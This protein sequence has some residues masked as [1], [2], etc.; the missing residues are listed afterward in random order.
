ME[1]EK[2]TTLTAITSGAKYFS[3]VRSPAPS[4]TQ[5]WNNPFETYKK[6][7]KVK[8]FIKKSSCVFLAC[9]VCSCDFFIGRLNNYCIG[10]YPAYICI[11]LHESADDYITTCYNV[12]V[13][14]VSVLGANFLLSCFYIASLWLRRFLRIG[15]RHVVLP[16][17]SSVYG[18]KE[19]GD[20]DK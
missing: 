1:N 19:L 12:E 18:V 8:Y 20:V 15:P 16:H 6:R 13:V 17:L 9:V 2:D 10:M 11:I 3:N 5:T 14:C 7:C 4:H